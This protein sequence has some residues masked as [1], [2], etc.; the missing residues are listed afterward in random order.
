MDVQRVALL[1]KQQKTLLF[2]PAAKDVPMPPM[3][4]DPEG[5]AHGCAPFFDRAMDG[6]SKNPRS[7]ESIGVP[8]TGKAFFFG[9]VSF[10][11]YQKK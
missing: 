10:D 7:N 3:R 11:A 6:E 4:Q 1:G 2:A 8:C 5:C 9:S